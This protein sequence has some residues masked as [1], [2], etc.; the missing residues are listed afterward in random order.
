VFDNFGVADGIE[1]FLLAVLIYFL[2]VFL[3][4]NNNSKLVY[5]FIA[6]SVLAVIFTLFDLKVLSIVFLAFLCLSWI[7][8]I[9]IYNPS[10]KR[11][12]WNMSNRQMIKNISRDYQCTDEDLMDSCDNIIKA[13]QN[14]AKKE[15]GAL[16]V[17][18]PDEIPPAIIQ[19]GVLI[20]A[21]VSNELIE[22][23]FSKKTPLHDGALFIKA[24]KIIAAGCFLPLTQETN[25]PKELGTRHRAAIGISEQ[26]NFFAIAVSEETG[27]ISIAQK[28][29]LTRFA[30]AQ[31]LKEKIYEVY[32]IK[33]SSDTNKKDWNWVK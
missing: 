20:N 3:K 15:T 22:T 2:F 17:L 19:S 13:L 11:F 18:T 9:V 10:I 28:G 29:E 21:V 27:I 4:Y 7:F 33:N 16:I 32:G 24:N 8:I 30:D 25:M 26:T 5:F 1:L 23:I 6:I 31:M 12:F 14:M